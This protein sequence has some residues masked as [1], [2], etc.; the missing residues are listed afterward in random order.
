MA[1]QG[2]PV[3]AVDY[4]DNK[5]RKAKIVDVLEVEIAGQTR[6]VALIRFDYME[7]IEGYDLMQK[8]YLADLIKEEDVREEYITQDGSLAIITSNGEEKGVCSGNIID[9]KK[10]I[11]FIYKADKKYKENGFKYSALIPK[12]K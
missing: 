7:N 3:Y 2:K 1:L 6:V 10:L 4:F 11:D 5:F 8:Q 12:A 9:T